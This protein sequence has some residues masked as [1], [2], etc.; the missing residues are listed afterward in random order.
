[1][2]WKSILLIILILCI[3]GLLAWWL[4]FRNDSPDWKVYKNDLLG[5]E[6]R[7]PDDWN[8]WDKNDGYMFTMFSPWTKDQIDSRDGSYFPA[9]EIHKL[10]AFENIDGDSLAHQKEIVERLYGNMR[11]SEI[12]CSIEE[13]EIGGL[14]A[15]LVRVNDNLAETTEYWAVR[16]LERYYISYFFPLDHPEYENIFQEIINSFYFSEQ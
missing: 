13:S 4:F 1:M 14:P 7:Y 12:I 3:I 5:L 16:D 15:I 6:L 10:K 11:D 8:L 9:L 2:N